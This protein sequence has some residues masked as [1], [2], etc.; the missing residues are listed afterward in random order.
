[1]LYGEDMDQESINSGEVTTI[2][3]Q[4]ERLKAKWNELASN[5]VLLWKLLEQHEDYSIIDLDK[6]HY[7]CNQLMT[8][9]LD[10]LGTEHMT[11][12]LHVIGSGHVT[13][14]AR[15]YKNLYRY[16]QQGWE[17][18]NQLIKH[19]Y[20]NNTNHG[21]SAGNGGKNAAGQYVNGTI[22]GDHCRPLM[23]LCQ[24]TIMWKLG[25]A[26]AYFEGSQRNN[27]G[28]QSKG[29]ENMEL[30]LDE[31]IDDSMQYGEL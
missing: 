2:R 8:Q 29:T 23:R 18:F 30:D 27:V 10:L 12:Y 21:G 28:T 4:N 11:N 24:R 19:F 22:S 31:N 13:Y 6:L 20:F 5:Q 17:A 1:V 25:L 16:S 9:W 14:F 15:K 7:C 26:D 3:H